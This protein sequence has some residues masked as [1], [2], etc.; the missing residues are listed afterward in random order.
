MAEGDV[1][2][3]IF[4]HSATVS[5]RNN[6]RIWLMCIGAL[7]CDR[8]EIYRIARC[9]FLTRCLANAVEDATSHPFLIRPARQTTTSLDYEVSW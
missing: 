1:N 2:A 9:P 3:L 8:K 4:V 5:R 7:G 6:I